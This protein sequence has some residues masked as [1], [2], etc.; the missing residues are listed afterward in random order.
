MSNQR[1]SFGS[2][3]N[4]FIDNSITN[5][6]FDRKLK[7][8]I[9]HLS[10]TFSKSI[11]KK[12]FIDIGCGSGLF[13]LAAIKLNASKVL[14]FDFDLNSVNT[15]NKLLSL[16]GVDKEKANS[17]QHDIRNEIILSNYLNAEQSK[18]I[19]KFIY[20][21][22]VVHHTGNVYL[23]MDNVSKLANNKN[24]E[25]FISIYNKIP[26]LTFLWWLEKKIYINVGIWRRLALFIW[27]FAWSSYWILKLQ[28]P[29]KNIQ[30]YGDNDRGMSFLTDA[31]DWLGGYPYEPLY[32]EDVIAFFKK[33]NFELINF[34]RGGN[35][36]LNDYLFKKV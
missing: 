1:F 22:G 36:G 21:A 28:N 35:W 3:W 13:S 30:R 32:K 23:S 6:S 16:K 19:Q 2:N 12:I 4:E 24:D 18:K 34:N 9:N 11:D 15:T 33:R 20:C 17:L 5:K 29:I 14:S 27:L 8:C 25:I 26:V 7:Y 31:K 10:N